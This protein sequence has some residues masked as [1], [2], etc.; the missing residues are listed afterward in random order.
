MS[1]T[2]LIV[3]GSLALS[4]IF[5][6]WLIRRAPEGREDQEG[7]HDRPAEKPE[8]EGEGETGRP[9]VRKVG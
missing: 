3:A 5:V 9:E 7:F 2:F 8:A 4:V 1:A 6:L